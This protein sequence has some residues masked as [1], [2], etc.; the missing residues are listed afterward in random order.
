MTNE[1][2]RTAPA[3][4]ATAQRAMDE[5]RAGET[6]RQ[7][8][9]ED[10]K[11]AGSPKEE[12][13]YQGPELAA[14]ARLVGDPDWPEA[15]LY[16]AIVCGMPRNLHAMDDERRCEVLSRAPPLTGTPWDA[17]I[18]AM[19]EHSADRHGHPHSAWMDEPERFL[20]IPWMPYVL[21]PIMH[22]QAL[23]FTP[24][25]FA[26]HGALVHPSDLD[27]RSGDPVWEEVLP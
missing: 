20:D 19:A 13:R 10:A 25:A 21:L 4:S 5:T 1:E 7:G 16:R 12:Y 3:R 2:E 17:M 18:A 27:E 15:D 6:R 11:Q 9:D 8:A 24:A 23:L 22:W 14:Y 26:R